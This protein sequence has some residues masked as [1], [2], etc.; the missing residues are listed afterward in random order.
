MDA[1]IS[2]R[3]RYGIR[4]LLIAATILFVLAIFSVWAN[5]QVLNED[6]WAD[7]SSQLLDD[8]AIRS[9]IAIYLVDEIYNNVNVAAELQTSLPP[10][11][12]P[13]AGPLAGGLRQVAERTTTTLL[14]R[15]RV[16]TAWKEANRITAGQF[17]RLAEGDSKAVGTSGN[18]VILDLRVLVL[19]LVQRLGLPGKLAA[20]IPPSAGKI[21]IL[22]SSQ[23]SA[24]QDGASFLKGLAL[25]LPILSLGMFALAVGLARGRRRQTLAWVAV[26]LIGAAAVVL[27]A[28]RLLGG[29]VVDS[30]A[31]DGAVRPA[32]E[33]AWSIATGILQDVAQATIIGALPLLFAAWLAGPSRPAV[34]A[35]SR[36]APTLRERPAVAYAVL[37]FVLLLI[38]AWG[39]IPATQK[40]IPV[41]VMVALSVLGLELLRRQT[42]E[43]FTP[44]APPAPD[45]TPAGGRPLQP[46]GS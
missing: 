19:D 24:V 1:T 41:L 7:T 5:R 42:A 9:Q 13:L 32:A 14:G 40:V 18:A 37:A 20:K 10:R 4:A 33:D 8:P 38:V 6:N 43:E 21:K 15:P 11:L 3:R 39:P 23:I 30:L 45:G 46:M 26:D 2:R 29:A 17:I 44:V 34:A 12:Q 36:L 25:V 16:Q 22:D 35:R 27:I 28:R 31:P